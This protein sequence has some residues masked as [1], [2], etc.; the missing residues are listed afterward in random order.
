M[1]LRRNTNKEENQEGKHAQN[2][3]ATAKR[4]LL[5]RSGWLSV[6]LILMM[7]VGAVF[8]AMLILVDVIPPDLIAIFVGIFLLLLI[9]ARL[10]FGTKKKFPH[11]IGI[12][13]ALIFFV[14]YGLGIGY[15]TSTYA[16]F[17]KISG[18]EQGRVST[19][20]KDITEEAFNIYV[21]GIDQ[22]STEKGYDLERSD[23]NMIVTINPL[24]HKIML[25]SIPRDT[26]VKLH[27]AQQMDKL[28]HTGIYGVDETINTVEDWLGV[29][30]D[31]Y[32]KINFTAVVSIINAMGGIDVDSPIEFNPVKMPDW[33]V[34]KGMNHMTGRQAL[35]FARERKAFEEQ[36]STRI[37][38]QQIVVE[39][40]IKKLVSST[41]LLTRY[42]DIMEAAGDNM[43]TDMSVKEMSELVKMQ[44]A[45]PGTWEIESQKIEG[46]YDMDYVA[47]L[48]SKQQYSILRPKDESVEKVK[49]EIDRIS[50]PTEEEVAEA[51][52]NR[53]IQSTINFLKSIVDKSDESDEEE[54]E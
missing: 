16:M 47:S 27:T 21:T 9:L 17:N 38:N 6:V 52:K 12:L 5:P 50:N 45:H 41:T 34:K 18:S 23:A 49:R 7:I 37:E 39:A 51:R 14:L 35:A 26:Y 3:G 42:G 31:Y 1:T 25:T 46:D 44:L 54:E 19:N 4:G 24:T 11:F 2:K 8:L 29:E 22:W 15:L 20:N 40:M 36:D 10:L 30:M 48:S 53:G 33:T 43:T 13:I 28:T 32:V